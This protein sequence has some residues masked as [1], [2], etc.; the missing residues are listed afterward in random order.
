MPSTI[1]LFVPGIV[2]VSK[3]V[4][5][6][7][8]GQ[9][10]IWIIILYLFMIGMIGCALTPEKSSRTKFSISNRSEIRLILSRFKYAL[11]NGMQQKSA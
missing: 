9:C 6:M 2:F 7:D 11:A 10:V 5:N 4:R 1:G 8:T 3:D